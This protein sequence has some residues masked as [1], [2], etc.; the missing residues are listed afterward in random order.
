MSFFTPPLKQKNGASQRQDKLSLTLSQGKRKRTAKQLD[1]KDDDDKEN[2]LKNIM[3]TQDSEESSSGS[4]SECEVFFDATSSK[5]IDTT[6]KMNNSFALDFQVSSVAVD[7]AG[8]FVVAGFNNGTIRLYPLNTNNTTTAPIIVGSLETDENSSIDENKLLFRKGVVLE[9]ISARG[10]YTQLRVNVVIP[11]DGRFIFAGVYRGSTEILVIDIDSIRLP[12][13][14]IGVPTAEVNTHC[15]ND[16]KLRGFGAVRAMPGKSAITTEYQVLCGLGIKNLHL[17]RFYW[18][19]TCDDPESKWTWQC[20]FDRQT[21]G[22]SLEYLAFG[23]APNQLISKSEHQ[24]IRVWTIDE[25]A[26][27][28]TFDYEDIK[29]TQDTIQVCGHYA[30]GGQERLALVDIQTNQRIELDLPSSSM[31]PISRPTLNNRKRQLRTLSMLTGVPA[32]ITLGVC[33]DG[34]V[35]VHDSSNKIGLGIHTPPSPLEGYDAFYQDQAGLLSLLPLEGSSDMMD[36]IVVMAN[37]AELQVQKLHEFLHLP[38]R[39]SKIPSKPRILKEAPL[40]QNLSEPSS[41]PSKLNL[42]QLLEKKSTKK[43]KKEKSRRWNYDVSSPKKRRERETTRESMEPEVT[44]EI[45]HETPVKEITKMHLSESFEDIVRV[46]TPELSSVDSDIYHTPQAKKP[47]LREEEVLSPVVS[48]SPVSSP[49]L[50]QTPYNSPPPP[51]PAKEW[52]PFVIPKKSKPTGI[53]T[54]KT[55]DLPKELPHEQEPSP[56][57]NAVV[58]ASVEELRATKNAS[59]RGNSKSLKLEN[60][61]EVNLEHISTSLTSQ[62]DVDMPDISVAETSSVE[63]ETADESEESTSQKSLLM[64]TTYYEMDESNFVTPDTE[65]VRSTLQR[66]EKERAELTHNFTSA[67]H[68]LIRSVCTQMHRQKNPVRVDPK[69]IRLQFH[70][71]V[72]ELMGQQKMEADALYASHHM[73]WTVLGLGGFAMPRLEPTFPAPR[74]FG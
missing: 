62:N 14:V 12:N 9:H 72:N 37:S 63:Y 60:I 44:K 47:K 51:P 40:K 68:N 59:D 7:R 18:D 38:K 48:I 32:G 66:F 16:A 54:S 21:N 58:K 28:M 42:E 10:M 26:D 70:Q 74:L 61:V 53:E 50:P 33:S 8:R 23:A 39:E 67:H 20:I 41:P 71:R 49:C 64:Q 2:Q 55:G 11:E 30:Y 24:S 43:P 3:I 27:A 69:V 17:W 5:P 4:D 35:F 19:P 22:I 36:W 45:V 31:A 57:R 6:E 15:Y 13:D 46:K 73:Q 52:S 29:Q 1:T 65:L 34:S 56:E 25:T